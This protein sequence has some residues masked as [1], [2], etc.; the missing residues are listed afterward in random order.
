MDDR[1]WRVVVPD[2]DRD[3]SESG[4]AGCA[5][6]RESACPT[7]STEGA[8]EEALRSRAYAEGGATGLPDEQRM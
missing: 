7:G 1:E 5:V 3:G 6:V 2:R 8:E 4:G